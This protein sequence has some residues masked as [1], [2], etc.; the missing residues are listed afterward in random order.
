[1]QQA[2]REERN[3]LKGGYEMKVRKQKEV[4]FT[5][6]ELLVV[7]AI[8]AILA[9][10]LFPVFARAR[11]KARTGSCQS[12][13]K[14]IAHGL[15]MYVNDYDQVL[16][17]RN[18]GATVNYCIVDQLFPYVKNEQ[19]FVCPSLP[20]GHGSYPPNHPRSSCVAYNLSY[21]CNEHLFGDGVRH[22][23]YITYPGRA[24]TFA[25]IN[26]YFFRAEDAGQIGRLPNRHLDG[27]NAA[28]YDGHVK[29][30]KREAAFY[31]LRRG[32]TP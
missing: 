19:L 3:S 23:T 6:I 26:H 22:E 17:Y 12:N 5:L 14:Q 30:F 8:I 21:G 27:L 18:W 7:I 11:E 16:P 31:E 25:D 2:K 15:A 9:A 10:I 20:T 29:W 1:V 4:G 24:Y 32:L 28:F 13:L